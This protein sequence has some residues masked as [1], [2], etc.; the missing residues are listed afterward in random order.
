MREEE[1]PSIR[2]RA[3]KNPR[4]LEDE[5]INETDPKVTE[6]AEKVPKPPGWLKRH[7]TSTTTVYQKTG[8]TD[9]KDP[10]R[11]KRLPLKIEKLTNHTVQ[12]EKGSLLRRS[13]VSFRSAAEESQITDTND[14]C[15]P[16]P[17]KYLKS[18]PSKYLKSTPGPS[19]PA[20]ST[21]GPS[22]PA[23]STPGP[24]EPTKFKRKA[25][26]EQIAM[27]KAKKSVK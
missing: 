5:E 20:K 6:V 23:K 2:T 18:S 17:S 12:M 8:K 21:P 22:E 25:D 27:G 3:E 4:I 19:E 11:Y 13:G 24:S 14:A 1:R 7:K 26:K 10:R 9:P 16:G 15:T